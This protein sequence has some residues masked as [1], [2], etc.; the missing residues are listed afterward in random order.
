MLILKIS[1]FFKV[2]KCLDPIPLVYALYTLENIDN[3][4]WP[5]ANVEL[6]PIHTMCFGLGHILKCLFC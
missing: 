2:Y 4:G 6:H 5:L 3:Y 1:I